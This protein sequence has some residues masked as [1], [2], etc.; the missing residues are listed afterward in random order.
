MA[1]EKEAPD[2]EEEVPQKKS[3]TLFFIIVGV[4]LLLLA[5]GGFFTYTTFLAPPHD[6][7][8]REP[9]GEMFALEPFVVNLA[10]PTGKRYLK[11]QIALELESERAVEN[12][13][14]A[15]PK[16]R[17]TVITMLTALSFE[18]VMTPEGKIRIRDE[19]LGRFNVVMRPDR[20]R[21]IYFTEFV[22]Q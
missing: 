19:L 12:A 16:L 14:R 18:E 11:V 21:N 17:D 9:L 4:A 13:K 8:A 7:D 6:E 2:N 10:D 3:K 20:V 15:E 22:V 1:E 5:G